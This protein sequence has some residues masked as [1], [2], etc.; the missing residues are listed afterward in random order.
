MMTQTEI[1]INKRVKLVRE[2]L[3][4]SQAQFSRIISLSNGYL[5]GVETEKR[6][7]NDRL[8]K[9]VCAAFNVNNVWLKTGEGEMFNK[10]HNPF[11]KV[12]ALYK[13]LNSEYQGYVLRQIELLLDIQSKKTE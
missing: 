9:L 13:E 4:L 8:V 10:S 11:T 12:M 7:V 2:T 1:T 3:K 6:R 5:G